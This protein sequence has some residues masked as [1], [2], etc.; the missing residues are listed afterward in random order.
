MLFGYKVQSSEYFLISKS[1]GTVFKYF[2]A[3]ASKPFSK[4]GRY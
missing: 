2:F 4:G 1:Q 3:S